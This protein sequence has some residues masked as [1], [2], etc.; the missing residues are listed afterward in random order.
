MPKLTKGNFKSGFCFKLFTTK[1]QA[2]KYLNENF[3]EAK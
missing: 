2:E 3:K 1:E